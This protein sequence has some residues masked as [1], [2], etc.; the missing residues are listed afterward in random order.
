[1]SGIF[2]VFLVLVVAVFTGVSTATHCPG[3]LD[4]TRIN[5]SCQ[6]TGDNA[7]AID[8]QNPAQRKHL[9]ADAQL[10]EDLAIRSADAEFNRLYG[11]EAHGGL[12]DHGRVVRECM[13]RL[14]AAIEQNHAVTMD[15]V[16]SAR[17]E[18][19]V[20]FDTAA[21]LSFVP[22]FVFGA[23]VACRGVQ[24]RFA[25][26]RRAVRL[27]ATGLASIAASVLTYQLGHLWLGVWETVRVRNGHISAFRAATWNSWPQH[28]SVALFIG[29]IGAFWVVALA[30][31]RLPRAVAVTAAAFACTMV[32]AMFVDVF[33]Q[34]ALGYALVIGVPLGIVATRFAEG[35][36]AGSGA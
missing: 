10:A 24:R 33:V 28:H 26:D 12:I 15:Q 14:V 25:S 31:N 35:S 30:V 20:Q 21:A 11:Y 8:R 13:A 19:D 32:G 34:S 5:K 29:A 9:V 6:W 22:V 4:R 1:M 2:T 36:S 7:F 16:A 23:T 27:V 18:R 3:C 17:G